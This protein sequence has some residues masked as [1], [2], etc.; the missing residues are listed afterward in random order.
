MHSENTRGWG[1]TLFDIRYISVQCSDT[2]CSVL[3][4]S[5]LY[6][7]LCSVVIFP[8]VDSTNFLSGQWKDLEEEIG[9]EEFLCRNINQPPVTDALRGGG[10]DVLVGW[11]EGGG[12]LGGIEGEGGSKLE[13]RQ[14]FLLAAGCNFSWW[15]TDTEAQWHTDTCSRQCH[16]LHWAIEQTQIQT[17]RHRNTDMHRNTEQTMPH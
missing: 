15:H 9:L 2:L 8:W 7:T 4:C 6:S 16:T 13:R 14:S 10:C 3:L 12:G 11:L 5:V 17:H 1:T